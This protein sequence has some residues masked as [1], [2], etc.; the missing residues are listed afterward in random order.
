MEKEGFILLK[1][2]SAGISLAVF[3]IMG[4]ILFILVSAVGD[5]GNP[6]Q[7]TVAKLNKKEKQLKEKEETLRHVEK[8]LKMLK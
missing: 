3:M 1:E 2:S 4:L 5:E 7:A 6:Q 8:Q